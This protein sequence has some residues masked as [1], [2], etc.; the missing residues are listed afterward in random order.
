MLQKLKKALGNDRAEANYFSTVVFIFIAVL[1][2]AFI[3]DLFSIISTK[4]ELD[5]AADQMV[6]Q[7]Q[8]SG[9]INGETEELFSFL[10]SQI[11][12]A[13]NIS[14]SIDATYK[15]PRPSGMSRAIQLGSPFYITIEGSAKLGGF[16]NFDLVRITVVSRG[17]GVSEHYW[18]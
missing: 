5:H 10:C 6:K 1:L 12:G 18:K 7:I 14:Y 4:Q 9:G 3:I 17:A 16:W 13:D 15:T 2:L 11:E 8:L